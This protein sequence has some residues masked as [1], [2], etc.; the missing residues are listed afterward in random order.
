MNP[1]CPERF[2]LVRGGVMTKMPVLP[3]GIVSRLRHALAAR[4]LIVTMRAARSHLMMQ[5][6]KGIIHV[7]ANVGQE[8]DDYAT[9]GLN[10]LWIEPIP[11][12]FAQLKSR[13]AS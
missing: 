4:G 11:W 5:R 9:Y 3:S 13:I 10:V 2:P 1:R 6:L 7:G 8:R 12:L